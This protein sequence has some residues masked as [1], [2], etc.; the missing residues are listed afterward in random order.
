MSLQ[1][2]QQLLLFSLRCVV[3]AHIRSFTCTPSH[4]IALPLLLQ[5]CCTVQFVTSTGSDAEGVRAA[6]VDMRGASRPLDV[7]R[8]LL[9]AHPHDVLASLERALSSAPLKVALHGS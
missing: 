4:R 9:S 2:L 3:H 5:T 1:I 6:P 8:A 7:V